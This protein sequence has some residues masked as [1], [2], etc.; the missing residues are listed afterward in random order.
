MTSELLR[1]IESLLLLLELLK[2]MMPCFSTV[3]NLKLRKFLG[4]IRTVLKKSI[5]NFTDSDYSSNR[6]RGTCTKRR[7]SKYQ[8]MVSLEKLSP[9]QWFF[10][11]KYKSKISLTWWWRRL[12]RHC[13]WS[14][15]KRYFSTILVYKRPK[16]RMS[17]DQIKEN[18]FTLKMAINRRYPT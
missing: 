15:A 18:G 5:N 3:S 11:W 8:C 13:Q 17:I 1:T 7:W 12:F 16:L 9:M 14:L 2:S 10:F 6:R 4:K